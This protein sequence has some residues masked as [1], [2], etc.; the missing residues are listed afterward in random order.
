MLVEKKLRD[1]TKEEFKEW[2]SRNC[3]KIE[4]ID[5]PFISVNCGAYATKNWIDSK[6]IFKDDFLNKKIPVKLPDVLDEVEKKYLANIIRPFRDKVIKIRKEAS[7][8]YM[9]KARIGIDTTGMTT[10]LP[11]FNAKDMYVNME[12][13]TNYTLEELGL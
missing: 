8:Y 11:Y 7:Y 1:V 4:C 3:G 5:C 2:V 12:N 10:W 6:D 13:D 9:D